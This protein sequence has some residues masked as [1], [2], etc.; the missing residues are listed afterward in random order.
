MEKVNVLKYIQKIKKI[1]RLKNDAELADALNMKRSN[2]SIRKRRGTLI[3]VILDYIMSEHLDLNDFFYGAPVQ[4]E[5]AQQEIQVY[6]QSLPAP[7]GPTAVTENGSQ[8]ETENLNVDILA[9]VLRSLRK[10]NILPPGKINDPDIEAEI[11]AEL[12]N[13]RLSLAGDDPEVSRIDF[14]DV[15]RAD[16]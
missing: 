11:I 7:D 12:Y 1:K 16:D 10:R 15:N 9:D 14:C 2:F 4:I 6:P 8:P 13:T 3:E 5:P